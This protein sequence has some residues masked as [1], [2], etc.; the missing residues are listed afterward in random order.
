M[1]GV[2]RRDQ[3]EPTRVFRDIMKKLMSLAAVSALML[4]AGEPQRPKILG[5][6]HIAIF[7]RDIEQSR[8]F[9]RDF[10]GFQEP[11]VLKNPNGFLSMT[12]FKINDRQYIEL[13]P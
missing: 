3:T 7:A 5:V 4:T 6:A 11:Y 2:Y 8:A 13:S 1:A 12:F 10:L 9:Y